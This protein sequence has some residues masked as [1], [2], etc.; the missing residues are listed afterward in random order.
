[1]DDEQLEGGL[2]NP[3]AVV[4]SGR[5][6]L[7]PSGPHATSVHAFLRAVRRTG[8]AGVPMPFGIDEHGREQ[9]EFVDGDVPHAPYPAWSQ[10]DSA[11]ASVAELLRGLHE[12]SHGFDPRVAL[13]GGEGRCQA[14]TTTV[15]A[16]SGTSRQGR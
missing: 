15:E 9:L 6:V 4:R 11:L 1:M 3:G 5:Q 13:R 7:R 16:C 10:S 12:A 14:Q 2:S 8:F